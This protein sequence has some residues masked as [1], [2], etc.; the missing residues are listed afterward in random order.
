LSPQTAGHFCDTIVTTIWSVSPDHHE[1]LAPKQ[2]TAGA[3][4]PSRIFVDIRVRQSLNG[5]HA[6]V[7][8]VGGF[9]SGFDCAGR[10]SARLV[11]RGQP[12]LSRHRAFPF[13][14]TPPA[15]MVTPQIQH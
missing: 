9:A 12:A 2:K 7:S 5:F 8:L 14:S 11:G 3:P 6:L 13:R 15:A 4:V 10:Q 1:D